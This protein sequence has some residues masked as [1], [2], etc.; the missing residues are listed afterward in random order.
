MSPATSSTAG[1][2][3]WNAAVPPNG[4]HNRP[5]TPDQ[6]NDNP[7]GLETPVG[8][9]EI[10]TTPEHRNLVTGDPRC[11][12]WTRAHDDRRRGGSRQ[13]WSLVRTVLCSDVDR[14]DENS[15]VGILDHTHTSSLSQ[16][17]GRREEGGGSRLHP[18]SRNCRA[19]ISCAGPAPAEPS[20]YGTGVLDYPLGNARR[21]ASR[22]DRS[23][24]G[25]PRAGSRTGLKPSRRRDYRA[26][27][28]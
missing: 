17:P 20:G 25:A 5:A 8:E 27:H 13:R 28:R 3:G 18:R 22:R 21:R 11:T 4:F 19:P 2:I 9:V 10:E 7:L 6:G 15:N 26:S 16:A 1:R 12:D 23:G 14:L 24:L